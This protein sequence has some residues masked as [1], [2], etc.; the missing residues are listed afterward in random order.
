MIIVQMFFLSFLFSSKDTGLNVSKIL[1][2]EWKLDTFS[3]NEKNALKSTEFKYHILLSQI[4]QDPNQLSGKL[5]KDNKNALFDVNINVHESLVSPIIISYKKSNADSESI[6]E[7]QTF[8][9][10]ADPGSYG[11]LSGM[12]QLPSGE[13]FSMIMVAPDDF[14]FTVFNDKKEITI[15]RMSKIDQHQTLKDNAK[16]LPL[17]L[18]FLVGFAI[19]GFSRKKVYNGKQN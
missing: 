8:Q 1:K 5:E 11:A 4:A 2:G 18:T 16:K 3:L 6:S 9:I 12:G 17:L 10:S 19:F 7:E 14:E 13:Q 15:Y